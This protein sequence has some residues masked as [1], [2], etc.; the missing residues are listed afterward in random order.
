MQIRSRR[1]WAARGSP[2]RGQRCSLAR[3]VLVVDDDPLVAP[4]LIVRT[5]QHGRRDVQSEWALMFDEVV[6]SAGSRAIRR[7]DS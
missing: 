2:S 6:V 4:T 1:P 5:G 7:T 3:L